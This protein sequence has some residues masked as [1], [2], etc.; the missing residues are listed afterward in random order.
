MSLG[1]KDFGRSRQTYTAESI[2]RSL[3]ELRSLEDEYLKEREEVNVKLRQVRK[4]I[5]YFQNLDPRQIQMF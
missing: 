1:N 3:K 2:E 5:E 4:D